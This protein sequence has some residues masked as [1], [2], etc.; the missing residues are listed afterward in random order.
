MTTRRTTTSICRLISLCCPSSSFHPPTLHVCRVSFITPPPLRK[1][2]SSLS[3][4]LPFCLSLYIYIWA[5]V[6]RFQVRLGLERIPSSSSSLFHTHSAWRQLE[7][8]WGGVDWSTTICMVK[9]G[10]QPPLFPT[11]APPPPPTTHSL[12]FQR[13]RFLGGK[14]FNEIFI[15]FNSNLYIQCAKKGIINSNI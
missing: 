10:K 12:R 14:N 9:L 7:E 1:S 3:L 2:V 8:G 5:Q 6:V 4:A 11:T 13:A 15:Y